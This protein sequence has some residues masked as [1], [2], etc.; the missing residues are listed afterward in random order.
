MSHW[1]ERYLGLAF[2]VA[3]WSK[4]PSTR[5]G[6]VITKNNRILSLGFNGIP[7]G[8]DDDSY[9]QPRETKIACVLH[10]EINS[11]LS[12]NS[13]LA[14]STLYV[15]GAPCSNCAATMIQVGIKRVVMPPVDKEFAKRWNWDLSEK[16][17]NE[18]GIEIVEL[19][20]N[21]SV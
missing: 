1:D 7:S 11:I 21:C 20:E 4:D 8:L 19:Q 14:D 3:S 10:A 18:V 6:A 13:P 12:S 2:H 5:C 17:F 15:T 9:L 16:M